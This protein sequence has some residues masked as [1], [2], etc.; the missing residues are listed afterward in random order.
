[1]IADIPIDGT[2]TV[3]HLFLSW[4]K[5]SII[6]YANFVIALGIRNKTMQP[7]AAMRMQNATSELDKSPRLP[8][9]APSS[10]KSGNTAN[11]TEQAK[12]ILLTPSERG[13]LV[14]IVNLLS[15]GKTASMR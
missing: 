14:L 6:Q 15:A 2:I 5:P 10:H 12:T 7:I 8:I 13:G 9:N 3:R 1:L 11:T 4:L